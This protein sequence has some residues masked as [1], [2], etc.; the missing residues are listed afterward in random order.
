MRRTKICLLI[1]FGLACLALPVIAVQK[2]ANKSRLTAYR[3]KNCV[4]CHSSLLEPVRVSAHFYEWLDSTHEKKGV[5]CEKCHGGNPSAKD[6]KT[7]HTGV[8]RAAFPQSSLN[9]K[10]LPATCGSC[11]QEGRRRI[12][13]EQAL[14]EASGVRRWAELLDLPPSHG[15]LSDHLAARDIGA[16]RQLSQRV[17]R[18]C[19]AVPRRARKGRRR[20]SRIQPSR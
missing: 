10:N 9:P 17:R 15:D 12:H 16:M 20:D 13:R 11:H 8:L 5:V 1:L 2:K 6:L 18:P 19:G 7:A 3:D 14:P 4:I